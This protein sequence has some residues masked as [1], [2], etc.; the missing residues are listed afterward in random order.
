[1]LYAYSV[2][3]QGLKQDLITKPLKHSYYADNL[4]S[5]FKR[6][7]L[8]ATCASCY[9]IWQESYNILSLRIIIETFFQ[10]QN[11]WNNLNIYKYDKISMYTAN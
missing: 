6:K 5:V 10:W 7:N 9:H 11:N 4:D 1:M 8:K 3:H 2:W